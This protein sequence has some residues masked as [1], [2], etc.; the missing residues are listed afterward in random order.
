MREKQ[1]KG[2]DGYQPTL[3]ITTNQVEDY[4]EITLRDNGIGIPE[5]IR[6][7]IFDPFFTTKPTGDGNA[8]LGLS[9][10]FEIIVQRHQ[11]KLKVESELNEYSEFEIQ[12]PIG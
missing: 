4:V 8:G 11:G 6:Q 3:I 5:D 12:L 1:L 7:K 9:I 2:I 10:S